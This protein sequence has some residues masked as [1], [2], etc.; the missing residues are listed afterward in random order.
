MNN[1][2]KA[3]VEEAKEAI[4]GDT[5]QILMGETDLESPIINRV[6]DLISR[7]VPKVKDKDGKPY[8][9][10][11]SDDQSLPSI[12]LSKGTYNLDKPLTVT[13]ADAINFRR[14]IIVEE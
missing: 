7:K 14:V 13:L 4:A 9:Y 5:L 6:A 1:K 12:T 2:D 8:I 10:I 11:A 3:R